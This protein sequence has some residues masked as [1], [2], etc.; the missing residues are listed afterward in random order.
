[1]IVSSTYSLSTQI[2]R[3]SKV[4]GRRA[5]VRRSYPR[6]ADWA[7]APKAGHFPPS[8]GSAQYQPSAFW[9]A[10]MFRS[11]FARLT[12]ARL[13]P[14][15]SVRACP[16]SPLTSPAHHRADPARIPVPRPVRR[17]PR[18]S[19]C[20]GCHRRTEQTCR[21]SA[22]TGRWPG[23][24]RS[25]PPSSRSGQWGKVP[26]CRH[27]FS[28]GRSRG[29]YQ[30]AHAGLRIGPENNYWAGGVAEAAW[31][32]YP[33]QA[34]LALQV[35]VRVGDHHRG[36]LQ[37]GGHLGKRSERAPLIAASLWLSTLPSRW[38]PSGSTEH[39]SAASTCL[40]C[41]TSPS[42]CVGMVRPFTM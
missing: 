30:H 40:A 33:I 18:S 35:L 16:W 7:S 26:V 22:D 8:S 15:H 39:S 13:S 42:T 3:C 5:S 27:C 31:S 32:R 1:M 11:S 17:A 29:H 38:A 36:E 4:T 2:L 14:R 28:G 41:R 34:R 20:S 12:V 37:V 10:T 21:W 19:G 25:V 24:P 23:H 9:S 6:H